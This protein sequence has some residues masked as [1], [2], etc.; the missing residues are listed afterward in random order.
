LVVLTRNLK[1]S[2][3][4]KKELEETFLQNRKTEHYLFTGVMELESSKPYLMK[5]S[6]LG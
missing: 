6:L 1:T 3:R 5:N 2:S 4:L